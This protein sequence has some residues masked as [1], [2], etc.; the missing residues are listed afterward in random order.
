MLFVHSVDKFGPSAIVNDTPLPSA[1][2]VSSLHAVFAAM[3]GRG[4]VSRSE[5]ARITGL[6]K[7]TMSEVAKALEEAGWIREAGLTVGGLGRRAA[8]YQLDERRAFALG[9]DLGGTKVHLGI[10]DLTGALAAYEMSM[11]LG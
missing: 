4:P 5:L 7:Q 10:S 11:T 2:R 6:S 3:R 9:I 8:M 1:I